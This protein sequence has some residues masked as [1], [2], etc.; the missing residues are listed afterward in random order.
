MYPEILSKKPLV[1]AIF[2]IRWV[3][4]PQPDRTLR[5]P[6]YQIL[7]GRLSGEIRSQ[8]PHWEPLPIAEFPE[9]L[10]P[11]LVQH[12]FRATEG[13]WPVLQLGPGL[14][15]V[16]ETEGYR[17]P[18]F[19]DQCLFAVEKLK[20]V[21]ADAKQS[22]QIA[23]VMLRYVDADLLT[24]ETPQ[25]FLEKLKVIAKVPDV[26]FEN[27]NISDE[28][29]G[30]DLQWV[31]RTHHPKG[32]A[33]F[34]IAQ[35]QKEGQSAIIWEIAMTSKGPD[36][37]DFLNQSADWLEA[38]HQMTDDWFFKLIDGELLEKYR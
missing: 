2:E 29:L 12:R 23:Q 38:A 24:D 3:L 21:Y 28:L 1:E 15:T 7:V 34:R 19:R 37:G 33:Q 27:T 14:L 16:N 35:G 10:V 26:L 6:Y 8:F 32:A 13:G 9:H 18:E 20:Q 36:V 31:F 25:D 17:W 11:H 4:T 30:L 5:D 22:L